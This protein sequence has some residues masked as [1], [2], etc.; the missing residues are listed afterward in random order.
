MEYHLELS[1]HDGTPM[2]CL[3]RKRAPPLKPR[4][5]GIHQIV[6]LQSATNT[7]TNRYP[8]RSTTNTIDTNSVESYDQP[9]QQQLR[10]QESI[11]TQ[12]ATLTKLLIKSSI[13][14]QVLNLYL[15]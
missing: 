12:F 14:K 8:N 5:P 7:T 9:Q 3:K 15:L 11:T 4:P 6:L 2:I 1:H 13:N 10:H